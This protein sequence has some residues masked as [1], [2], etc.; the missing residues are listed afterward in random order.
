MINKRFTFQSMNKK[1]S[2][3]GLIWMTEKKPKAILQISHG[4]TEYI[5][6]YDEFARYMADN[7][8]IVVGNDHIG[9][10]KSVNSEEEWGYFAKQQG[11]ECIVN[12]LHHVTDIMKNKYPELP[13]F[14]LG[15]SMGS[16]FARRYIIEYGKT[17]DGAIIMGTGNQ[18]FPMVFG[19]KLLIKL[20]T[21]LKGETYRSKLIQKIMFGSYNKRIK[22]AKTSN[23]WLT[24]DE[25][26]VEKYSKEPSCTF[27]FTL[28]GFNNLVNTI[29]YIKKKSNIEKVP[30]NLPILIT[31]G[32]EDPVGN[33]GKDV[34]TLYQGLKDA[35]LKNT[36]LKLYEG[37]RHEILNEVAR[38][39]VYHDI[40]EWILNNQK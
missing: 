8:I 40:L 28:N 34:K 19:G 32:E 23:D 15:H 24:T 14:L 9:H 18:P 36:K 17:I 5:E 29:L 39:T 11:S 4:M 25:A 33:Y 16:F 12:D 13:Y 30:K 7:G 27:I 26:I 37:C 20:V 35:G 3:H 1:N 38:P 6:R 21:L 31:S 10:G 2:I 22:N